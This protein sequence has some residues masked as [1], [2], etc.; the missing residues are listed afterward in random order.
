MILMFRK[1]VSFSTTANALKITLPK[2]LGLKKT[3]GHVL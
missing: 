2:L 1:L 3:A